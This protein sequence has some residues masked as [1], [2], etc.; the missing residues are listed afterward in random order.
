M[1]GAGAA[2]QKLR[3]AAVHHKANRD[4]DAFLAPHGPPLGAGNAA[5]PKAAF[6][7]AIPCAFHA[8]WPGS[9]AKCVTRLRHVVVLASGTYDP[10]GTAGTSSSVF[11][12][13]PAPL[14]SAAHAHGGHGNPETS[15]N[16]V[17]RCIIYG[18]LA[19]RPIPHPP[20]GPTYPRQ[21]H[22]N[23]TAPPAG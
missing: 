12:Y 17:L 14:A 21:H 18:G 10:A 15:V 22:A 11:M 8:C 1:C 9:W 23:G 2:A 3:T 13:T 7:F 19:R 4:E 5:L 20:R 6:C 16:Q